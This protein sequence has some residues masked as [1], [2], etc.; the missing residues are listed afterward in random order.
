MRVLWYMEWQR[1]GVACVTVSNTTKALGDL[2]AFNR[3]RTDVSIVAITGSNGK[4]STRKMTA[5]VVA[6]RFCTLST[7]GNLN[8]EI[9]LPLT[10]LDLNLDHQWAVVE[11]GMNRPGEIRRLAEICS[12]DVGVITNIG[13]AHLEGLGSL[14]A[15]MKA[16]GE[17]LEKINPVGT[18]ALNADDHR[19]LQLADYTSVNVLLFGLSEKAVIRALS[20]REK[21]EGLSFILALPEEKISVDLKTPASFMVSNALA[22]AAVGYL[23]GLTAKEI[24]DGL[25]DFKPVKG[26]MNILKT[27]KRIH[28]IDDTYNANP[29]SMA[30]AIKT[31]KTLKGNNRGILVVG[32]MLE[33][34]EHAESLH[35]KI[36]S[37]SAR[38]D[39]ARL[40][41][42]GQFAET[43][44]AGAKDADMDSSDI[45]TGT[46]EEIL[47]NITCWLGP[48]DWVLVKGSRGMAMESIVEGLLAWAGQ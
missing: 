12:P 11:L 27:R 24:K 15:V 9:G 19:L 34:G 31:L 3:K 29:G 25:E 8:N 21:D 20:I 5:G 39:I 6:R 41:V 28:I 46:K 16:K 4:T 13:P 10:L 1:K 36:G 7:R 48:G 30:A 35:R 14:D 40:Y 23:L 47:E 26:R 18:A 43:L 2:A 17:L 45:F 37:I 33:L 44:A 38:S 42:A 32:D 22:A